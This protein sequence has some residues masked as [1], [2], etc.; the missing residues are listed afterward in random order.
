MILHTILSKLA[1]YE[2]LGCSA[3]GVLLCENCAAGIETLPERCYRC[4]RLSLDNKTCQACRQ[5]SPLHSVRAHTAYRGLAKDIIWRLKF[6]GAQA[7][8]GEMARLMQDQIPIDDD[9]V[10]V[11]IPTATSR[12]RARGYDQAQL[13]ARSLARQNGI[14]YLACLRRRG[15]HHQVGANR[16]QRI[17]QLQQA[18][19]CVRPQRLADRHVVLVDDVLTTGATLEAAARVIKA[20]G[21]KRVS[22]V[23]FAQA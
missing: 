21:A 2:C 4:K 10:L 18:Y 20:A 13:L 19:Y 12:V 14:A 5:H 1:P 16:E 8:A 22:A 7:A 3:E 17:T 6:S 11:P 15:Q 9:I 23:V